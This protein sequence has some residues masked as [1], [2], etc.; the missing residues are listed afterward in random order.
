MGIMKLK[1]GQVWKAKENNNH[2]IKTIIV[3][4]QLSKGAWL[5][6][7]YDPSI[8]NPSYRNLYGLNESHYYS[9]NISE[10]E[11]LLLSE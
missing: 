10:L 5:C 3:I 6:R 11:L 8:K 1:I 9:H 4:K 7:A 2:F